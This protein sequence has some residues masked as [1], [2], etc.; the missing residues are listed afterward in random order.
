MKI[1]AEDKKE[2]LIMAGL[3]VVLLAVGVYNFRDV[4]RASPAETSLLASP[5]AQQNGSPMIAAVQDNEPSLNLETLRYSREVTYESGDRNPF[6][7]AAPIPHPDRNVRGTATPAP[8]PY[9]PTPTPIPP[10]PLKFYGFA[11]KQGE[12]KRI[13]LG[14]PDGRN[15]VAGLNEIVDLRYKVVKIEA[16]QVIIEDMLH[17]NRQTILLTP[18]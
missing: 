11:N 15:F 5:A 9:V 17:N 12:P 1:G 3:L 7:Y 14:A 10:N 4:L 13:F 16:N 6:A 2:V 8:T 18:R